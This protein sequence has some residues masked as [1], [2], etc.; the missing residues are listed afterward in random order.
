MPLFT[1]YDSDQLMVQIQQYLIDNGYWN[2]E[3]W[4]TDSGMLLMWLLSE[5][6]SVD[7]YAVNRAYEESFEETARRIDT[8]VQALHRK[9]FD[10]SKFLQ[11]TQFVV[12][13]RNQSL[14]Y[15]MSNP[16][17]TTNIRVEAAI[18]FTGKFKFRR[19]NMEQ[20]EGDLYEFGSDWY[21]INTNEI[22]LETPVEML[23]NY[24]YGIKDSVLGS[25]LGLANFSLKSGLSAVVDYL[26]TGQTEEISSFVNSSLNSSV[27]LEDISQIKSLTADTL[28]V[29]VHKN[30]WES[31]D[32]PKAY[33]SCAE[34]G[35]PN[36]MLEEFPIGTAFVLE[37][38]KNYRSSLFYRTNT[39]V[40]GTDA[41]WV[42]ESDEYCNI[43]LTPGSGYDLA[44]AVVNGGILQPDGSYN[45]KV[46]D[47]IYDSDLALRRF[48]VTLTAGG[49]PVD[50][51]IQVKGTTAN[52]FDCLYAS[53]TSFRLRG[54]VIPGNPN[55]FQS[56]TIYFVDRTNSSLLDVVAIKNFLKEKMYSNQALVSESDANRVLSQLRGVIGYNV[57][58]DDGIK[59]CV[60]PDNAAIRLAVSEIFA[61]SFF[62]YSFVDAVVK[63]IAFKGTIYHD[64]NLDES[65]FIV[66]FGI[67]KKYFNE[68]LTFAEALQ[69]IKANNEHVLDMTGKLCFGFYVEQSGIVNF[70]EEAGVDQDY[71]ELYFPD[72][73]DWNVTLTATSGSYQNA[74]IS[75]V[76]TFDK[77]TGAVAFTLNWVNE[78]VPFYVLIGRNNMSLQT[79]NNEVML[80]KYPVVSFVS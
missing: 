62:E 76:W 35:V 13:V 22:I 19:F 37:M 60:Y 40:E 67:L 3:I 17:T 42:F 64:G 56:H 20:V 63:D 71:F 51:Y 5:L 45:L 7:N 34:T 54:A 4:G 16:G 50:V 12:G 28:A 1:G 31:L 66:K 53:E 27:V 33:L 6:I 26:L 41:E 49:G 14:I 46:E 70:D 52:I 25:H 47:M 61:G 21:G 68:T 32:L 74:G 23:G 15:T 75:I 36:L 73:L 10:F 57:Y 18:K 55:F 30:R 9:G 59:V 11:N 8:L 58:K 43:M 44:P 65:E 38:W 48:S 29:E 78:D 24:I 69:I 72:R 2:T 79:K 80:G 39:L 77:A